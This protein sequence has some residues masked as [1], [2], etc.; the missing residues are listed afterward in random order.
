MSDQIV[1]SSVQPV[2]DVALAVLGGE[3]PVVVASCAFAACHSISDEKYKSARPGYPS[4]PTHQLP[5][6]GAEP[7]PGLARRPSAP[8]IDQT[9]D[10]HTAWRHKGDLLTSMPGIGKFVASILIGDMP[11]LGSLSR[12][13]I[14]ALT[15]VAAFPGNRPLLDTGSTV[16]FDLV[17]C[18][19][20]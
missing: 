12:R 19:A 7:P 16:S 15:C 6:Y 14:A 13:Q 2:G 20:F 9:V 3:R 18:V 17:A 11:E 8:S 1:A 4:S 10:Q 5:D